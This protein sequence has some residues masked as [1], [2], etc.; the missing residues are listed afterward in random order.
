MNLGAILQGLGGN[1]GS[2]AG[3]G[4]GIP[5]ARGGGISFT[6]GPNG[7]IVAAGGLGGA[8]IAGN[9]RAGGGGGNLPQDQLGATIFRALG[10]APPL[11]GNQPRG[12]SGMQQDA[13]DPDE[14]DL[15]RDDNQQDQNRNQ[16]PI[17]NLAE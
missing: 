3:G 14:E 12:G 4:F 10:L 2:G 6:V 15:P 5:Q 17:Q 1:A 9:A 7:N 16:V 8:G 11:G 13:A